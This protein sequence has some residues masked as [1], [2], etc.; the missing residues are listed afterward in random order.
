MTSA[1]VSE[2]E[3]PARPKKTLAQRWR[4]KDSQDARLAWALIL[5]TAIIVFGIIIFP[6]I[7]SIWI[8]FHKVGLSDLNNVLNTPFVG[9]DNFRA[10][11][12]DFAFKPGPLPPAWA[13][14][15]IFG[16]TWLALTS[17]NWGAALTTVVYSFLSTA[18]TVFL[19]L[20]ASLA[21]NKPFRG[22]GVSRAI[23]L[24]PYIA[25]IV[26]VAFVWRWI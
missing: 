26:G 14:S 13:E 1:S 15:N 7:F 18:W 9:L 5:P 21:L 22:R 16:K 11:I 19:G 8:S 2:E 17:W 4:S 23:F 25:P 12:N 20:I 10:V 3:T 6:A 24:F